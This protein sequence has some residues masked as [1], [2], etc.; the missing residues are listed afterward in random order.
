MGEI[1]PGGCVGRDDPR[2]DTLRRG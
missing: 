1:Y 2:Y